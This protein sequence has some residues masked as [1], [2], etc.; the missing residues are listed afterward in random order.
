MSLQR[1]KRMKRTRTK[2]RPANRIWDAAIEKLQSEGQCRY[3]GSAQDLQIAHIIG[4]EHDRIEEG[5]RGGVVRVV[6]AES[7][8]ILCLFHHQMYDAR[9]LDLL[10]FPYVDQQAQTVWD[11]G[12]TPKALRR[13]TGERA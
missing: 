8:V 2:N 12:R 10:A 3:C 6:D 9:Q 13:I 5:P 1:S 4:R 11:A 7:C